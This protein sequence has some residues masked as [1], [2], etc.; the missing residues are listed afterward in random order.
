MSDLA[1]YVN[2]VNADLAAGTISP[3]VANQLI[4]QAAILATPKGDLGSN[5]R[6]ALRYGHLKIDLT[7][8][9]P[10]PPLPDIWV[11]TPRPQPGDTVSSPRPTPVVSPP[12]PP[13]VPPNTWD[14]KSTYVAPTGIKQASPDIIV[15][16][17]EIDP[18]FLVQMFF[19]EFGG[20]ELINISRYDLINGENVSYSPIV[21]LSSIRQSFNPN[22]IIAIG[23]FQEVPTKYGI[24]LFGRGVAGP[25][26]DDGGNLV[27]EIDDVRPNESIE[28]EI[29][30][31]GTINR[32]EL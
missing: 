22:N 28:V 4:Q 1:K 23:A 6:V 7:P 9:P 10:P 32:I 26:F 11:P 2:K 5:D 19:Q 27:I 12:P 18:D 14:T 29:A 15:F 13:P 20:T 3:Q 17:Q 8:P 31:D 30:S 21:N 16:D 24:N 25:Y